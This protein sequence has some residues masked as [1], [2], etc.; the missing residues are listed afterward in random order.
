MYFVSII[1]PQSYVQRVVSL[2]EDHT[3]EI[4]CPQDRENPLWVL[5]NL[6]VLLP[7]SALYGV[8]VQKYVIGMVVCKCTNHSFGLRLLQNN[9]KFKA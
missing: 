2:L 1:I 4:I 7:V 8:K 6:P 9:M 3:S 5:P